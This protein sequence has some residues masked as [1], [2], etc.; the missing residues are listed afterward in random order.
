[1]TAINQREITI[2]RRYAIKQDYAPMGLHKGDVVLVV[3][4]DAGKEYTITLRRNKAHSCTCV[5][6]MHS[7]RCYHVSTMVTLENAR[8]DAEKAKIPMSE[9]VYAKISSIN[10]A[11]TRGTLNGAQ[12]SARLLMMLPSRQKAKAS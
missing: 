8:F 12:Q 2:I 11:E 7:R 3:R 10:D 5:A 6:G 9:A 4:N 1:M